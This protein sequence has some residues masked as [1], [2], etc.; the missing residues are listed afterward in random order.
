MRKRATEGG[1]AQTLGLAEIERWNSMHAD[2]DETV[3]NNLSS[4]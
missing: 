2:D 1:A 3:L 4:V